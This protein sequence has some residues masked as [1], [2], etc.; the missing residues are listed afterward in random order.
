V[1]LLHATW[2]VGDFAALMTLDHILAPPVMKIR[3]VTVH[4]IPGSDHRAVIAELV[5]VGGS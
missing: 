4:E 5:A 3:R 2:P 1:R